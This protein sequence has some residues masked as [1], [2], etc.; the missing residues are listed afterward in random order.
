[1]NRVQAS[2]THGSLI[3]LSV[4]LPG[5]EHIEFLGCPNV[6]VSV[7]VG[8]SKTFAPECS[9]LNEWTPSNGRTWQG[10]F[11]E[12]E[13]KSPQP[14]LTITDFN[15]S[16]GTFTLN[17]DPSAVPD[18]YDLHYRITHESQAGS[19]YSSSFGG[20]VA[21]C[22]RVNSVPLPEVSDS[23]GEGYVKLSLTVNPAPGSHLVKVEPTPLPYSAEIGSTPVPQCKDTT[24]ACS[25]SIGDGAMA[26]FT[27]PSAP[28]NCTWTCG[29]EE[30][31]CSA[32]SFTVTE[33]VTCT[34]KAPTQQL[35]Y[36]TTGDGSGQ[37]DVYIDGTQFIGC[38]GQ[39]DLPKDKQIELRA[40]QSAGSDFR[41]W[42]G[43]C[44]GLGP[45]ATIVLDGDKTCTAEFAQNAA[46]DTLVVEL[47]NSDGMN[48][49]LFAEDNTPLTQQGSEYSAS[50]PHMTAVPLAIRTVGD[51]TIDFSVAWECGN[52]LSTTGHNVSIP[53]NGPTN[54]TAT[55]EREDP[56]AG[57]P[58]AIVPALLVRQNGSSVDST[59]SSP[60]TP[61]YPVATDFGVELT[62]VSSGGD[63]PLQVRW[64]LPAGPVFGTTYV[65]PNTSLDSGTHQ[66]ILEVTD[67]CQ[68]TESLIFDL[69]AR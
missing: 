7:A 56:C 41:G 60:E 14:W 34:M 9:W 8:D 10:H 62:S 37:V 30:L 6:S 65:W 53:V 54:C 26:N 28:S 58:T 66:V 25:F 17:I 57:T 39:C 42:Q 38:D 2:V 35:T 48:I 64:V 55:I 27:V 18:V 45:N 50:V 47:L 23:V 51:V 11:P 31:P 22:D 16:D 43:H 36:G 32:A 4:L 19:C 29:N 3:L 63:G 69:V 59:T 12:I 44:A 13:I 5:C 1:M 67:A 20:F 46:M 68:Q 52:T 61:S 15:S 33:D 24:S 49:E 40:T 21:G